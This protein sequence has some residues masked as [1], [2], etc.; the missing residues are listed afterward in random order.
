[1]RDITTRGQSNALKNCFVNTQSTYGEA[2]AFHL[3]EFPRNSG[4]TGHNHFFL[5]NQH[6]FVRNPL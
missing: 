6:D 5:E 2:E 1:M 3:N 4:A